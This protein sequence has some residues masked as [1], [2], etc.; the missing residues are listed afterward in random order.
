MRKSLF[1]LLCAALIS[2]ANTSS[3]ADLKTW[4][5]MQWQG[6]IR[7]GLDI[8]CGAAALLTLMN[9]DLAL[10]EQAFDESD[11]VAVTSLLLG[12]RLNEASAEK[13]SNIGFSMLDLSKQ[14]ESM[15]FKSRLVTFEQEALAD[16]VRVG[17]PA[18]VYVET[19]GFKHYIVV[20]S[21]DSGIVSVSDPSTGRLKLSARRFA[22]MWRGQTAL[23]VFRG[24][25]PKAFITNELKENETNA[26]KEI[27]SSR[28]K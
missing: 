22:A 28:L 4:D 7:Q 8:S 13:N 2:L 26:R 18:L 14:A 24:D 25:A 5:D 20:T 21:I 17:R 1:G 27:L 15:G 23:Y 3:A 16:F 10:N 9:Q 12:K 11:E 6:I 19:E